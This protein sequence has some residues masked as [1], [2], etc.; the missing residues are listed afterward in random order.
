M[1]VYVNADIDPGHTGAEQA[2]TEQPAAPQALPGATATQQI[3]VNGTTE[4]SGW[5]QFEGRQ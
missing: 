4:D 5:P 3:S 2:H 1:T